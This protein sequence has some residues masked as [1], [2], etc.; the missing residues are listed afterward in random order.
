MH[1]GRGDLFC[2]R[3]RERAHDWERQR[4][5]ERECEADPMLSIEPHLRAPSH[6]PE[7]MT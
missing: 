7:I 4:E 6:D 3:E 1:W 2:L 5:S